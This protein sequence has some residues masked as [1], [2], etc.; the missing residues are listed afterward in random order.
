MQWVLQWLQLLLSAVLFRQRQT[1]A[2]LAIEDAN[3][4]F[5]A[6]FRSGNIKVNTA[7]I[8]AGSSS[9]RQ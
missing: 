8:I 4:R 9:S 1:D 3:E 5:Y 7:A 6:A 2:R